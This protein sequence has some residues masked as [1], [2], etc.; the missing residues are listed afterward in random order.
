MWGLSAESGEN[1]VPITPGVGLLA[2][3]APSDDTSTQFQ[4][5]NFYSFLRNVYI[6]KTKNNPQY[7]MTKTKKLKNDFQIKPEN[8]MSLKNVWTN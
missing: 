2:Y 7:C 3:L 6:L 5:L 4:I 1:L 8:S